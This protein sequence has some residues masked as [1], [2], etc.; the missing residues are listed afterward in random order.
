VLIGRVVED[1][2]LRELAD[3]LSCSNQT[4]ANRQQ[5]AEELMK[6]CLENNGWT[7]EALYEIQK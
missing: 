2:N 3:V 7:P 5:K 1:L 6:K 4:V